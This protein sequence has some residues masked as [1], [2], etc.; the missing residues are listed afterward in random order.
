MER[1][2]IFKHEKGWGNYLHVDIHLR[3]LKLIIHMSYIH[4]VKI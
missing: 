2:K 3:P 4:T 1:V